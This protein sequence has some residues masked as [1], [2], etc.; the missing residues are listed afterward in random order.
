M[1]TQTM[2]LA[3]ALRVILFLTLVLSSSL[4]AEKVVRLYHPFIDDPVKSTF[5]P[6]L[7]HVSS[8][9]VMTPIGDNWWE[10]TITQNYNESFVFLV[11]STSTNGTR[12]GVQGVGD[13]THFGGYLN[14]ADTIWV[15]PD[16]TELART[17]I[18]VT[19]NPKSSL[20]VLGAT[21][22][23]FSKDHSDFEGQD[24]CGPG[25]TT[26]MVQPLIG[27]D[28]KP[29]K[30]KDDC[31]NENFQD[32]FND[33]DQSHTT[34]RD[35]VLKKNTNGVFEKK[36]DSFFPIDDFNKYN[37][38]FSTS[39]ENNYHF[40][41]ETHATFEYE[42]GETF[43]F[44]GDDDVWVYI[45]DSLVVDLGGL[46]MQER[47]AVNLDLLSLT[48]GEIYDFDFFFCER[49]RE[50]SRLQIQTTIKLRDLRQLQLMGGALNG[51]EREYVA[52]LLTPAE[53]QC[54]AEDSRSNTGAFYN[55]EYSAGGFNT[56]LNVGLNFEGIV[57]N[58]TTDT[59]TIDT[60][61]IVSLQSGEYRIV[62]SLPDS[63]DKKDTLYFNV[64][65]KSPTIETLPTDQ[66]VLEDGASKLLTI[67]IDDVDSGAQNLTL[68]AVSDKLDIIP[69]ANIQLSGTG[70]NRTIQIIPAT[71][72]FGGP[73]TITVTV[74]DGTGLANSSTSAQFTVTVLP[75]NDA[76]SFTGG[77]VLMINE[78]SGAQVFDWV[79]L[80]SEGPANESSQMIEYTIVSKR[81]AAWYSSAPV[82]DPV[83]GTIDFTVAPDKNGIDTLMV[84]IHDDG[85]TQDGG[86]ATGN[87]EP[88]YL[89]VN[90]IPIPLSDTFSKLENE[91][92]TIGV[93]AVLDVDDSLHVFNLIKTSDIFAMSPDGTL[94]LHDGVTLDYEAQQEHL[95]P[96]SIF[97]GTDTTFEVLTISVINII[98][99]VH[100]SID[101]IKDD[102][103]VT[104]N[105]GVTLYSNSDNVEVYFT[106]DALFESDY[107]SLVQGVNSIVRTRCDPVKD[108]CGSD[109]VIVKMNSVPPEVVLDSI[110]PQDTLWINDPTYQI[111]GII[112]SADSNFIWREY[113][114]TQPAVLIEG[115]CIPQIVDTT[116]IFGN[117][118]SAM[119][120]L[121]LD[122]TPPIVTIT[123]PVDS[124]TM[125]QFTTPVEWS[126]EGI[127]QSDLQQ[128]VLSDG[129]NSIVRCGFD[130]AGNQ[131]CDT[132]TVFV[133]FV[134]G[135]LEIRLERP[136]IQGNALQNAA[137]TMRAE[138]YY[139][140]ISY[141][142][143]SLINHETNEDIELQSGLTGIILEEERVIGEANIPENHYGPTVIVR[144]Q[145]P[146]IGGV[147]AEG[148]SRGGVDAQGNAIWDMKIV[149][150][151]HLFDHI[152]QFVDKF[153][154]E[155]PIN[156][157][158]Y[159]DDEGYATMRFEIKPTNN[160]VTDSKGTEYA[161]GVYLLSGTVQSI[162]TLNQYGYDSMNELSEIKKRNI[163]SNE[164]L[165]IK[166]GY[167]KSAH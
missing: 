77:P 75:V 29:V 7:W 146:H 26:E 134:V 109:T 111:I 158:E 80:A 133:H 62:A 1:I 18:V 144:S 54:G 10:T 123:T 83:T 129:E 66:T 90:D 112:G 160:G 20:L 128:E 94:Q 155:A 34:C 25:V 49:K 16:Y 105:T 67:T 30:N 57:I 107:N 52:T 117:S 47:G 32:W 68:S 162:A 149:M 157:S 125:N 9:T 142:G 101:S 148:E 37:E 156:K 145:F 51:S 19:N 120:V 124:I 89:V 72:Q 33:N 95:L 22:R 35:L 131:G 140:D 96:I 167:I 84:T 58:S 5:V 110:G 23:D 91:P 3:H 92:G 154:I 38:T 152:G 126:V 132:V 6:E 65:N 12:Y 31:Y 48:I 8:W 14:S 130:R 40:C 163:V 139:S 21:I 88:L 159:L 147:S 99:Q 4:F 15:R 166:F 60:A 39:G 119:Q 138:E 143:V 59:I 61:V 153:R 42:G 13:Y 36:D 17:P 55:L 137:T 50:F 151:I 114:F 102:G 121:C 64:A 87:S 82:L 100:L 41:M 74:D 46:H 118:G 24:K 27:V 165:F 161:S 85:G 164:N 93:V 53:I 2:H 11:D 136:L 127:I 98:E 86:I 78:N 71:N 70:S 43:E 135:N 122:T 115:E 79:I 113:P 104:P 81:D 108:M 97:D 56:L 73:V 44:Y 116:D 69:N 45:N 103:I 63:P 76:P 150:T 28:R 141:T 106:V